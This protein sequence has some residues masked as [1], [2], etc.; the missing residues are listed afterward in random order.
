MPPTWL[1]IA[2][3]LL[4]L[5]VYAFRYVAVRAHGLAPVDDSEGWHRETDSAGRWVR[6]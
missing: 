2:A 4:V 6:E 3:G 5:V 1:F